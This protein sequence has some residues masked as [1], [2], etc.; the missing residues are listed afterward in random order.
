MDTRPHSRADA[1]RPD[2]RVIFP[3][4]LTVF[5]ILVHGSALSPL[6]AEV[7]DDLDTT[8]P[9]VGQVVTLILF[10]MG[11]VALFV[12][13]LADHV[14][15][16]Q[17]IVRGL[18]TLLV[19]AVVM[20]LAPSIWVML[21]GGLIAGIGASIIGVPFAVAAIGWKGEGQQ[22]ALSRV[23]SAQT[24][25]SIL[26][27][28]ILTAVAAATHWRGAYVV[29][30]AT[31]VVAIVL[32]RRELAPD[33]RRDNG[34]FSIQTVL[35]AY[36]PLVAHHGMRRLYMASA[37]RGLG[38]FGPLIYLGAFYVDVHDFS[39][40][41]VGLALMA[42]SCGLFLGSVAAG[43]WLQRFDSR[44][45]YA[46]TTV[47][48]AA[49]FL[50]VFTLPMSAI[51]TI[52]VMTVATF[53]AGVGWV[54]LTALLASGTPAGAGTTMTL[55]VSVYTLSSAISV[56]IGG[57]LIDLGGYTL[58]GVVF[59]VVILLSA[60]VIWAPGH[61]PVALLEGGQPG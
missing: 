56:A 33:E 41:Q 30:I 4:C 13:P 50:V 58:L 22:R 5:A 35:D 24:L 61:T 2:W 25:G 43:E 8:V 45:I 46:A 59:P 17:T 60:I 20:G 11:V 52:A 37:T 21:L 57:L 12:G 14:G 40:R 23:Q 34:R 26:G 1:D 19:S 32:V 51:A 54:N 3:L 29:I 38:W 36:R 9:L 28:P 44:R 42:G 48:L 18:L 49:A 7:A 31:Y 16:R 6:A 47:F 15:H 27:A 55:N 53:C 10:G 39:L